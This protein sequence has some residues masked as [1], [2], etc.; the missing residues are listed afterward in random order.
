MSFNI[1]TAYLPSDLLD[2]DD[3][4]TQ[5]TLGMEAYI[6]NNILDD[7]DDTPSTSENS[8]NSGN[9]SRID[10]SPMNIQISPFKEQVKDEVIAGWKC[11]A[12]KNF[13]IK[14]RE[15]CKKCEKLR[16]TEDPDVTRKER[17]QMLKKAP[18]VNKVIEKDG[19]FVGI[20]RGD[21]VVE[22]EEYNHALDN[23][24]KKRKAANKKRD[25]GNWTCQSCFNHNFS[26]R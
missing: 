23:R 24:Q 8:P 10:I 9:N 14:Q 21:R 1:P 25:V 18:K 22:F 2:S 5:D 12:C 3:D 11:L 15:E 7:D 17:K 13:N 19:K 26:F 16:A 20:T 6:L 4:V